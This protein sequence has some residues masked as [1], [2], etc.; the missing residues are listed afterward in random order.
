MGIKSFLFGVETTQAATSLY[1]RNMFQWTNNG[2]PVYFADDRTTYIQEGYENVGAVYEC[3]DLILKKVVACPV[4]VY[5]IK[6]EQKYQKY[7]NLLE[8]GTVE[9]KAL[10]LSMKASVLSEVTVTDI[11]KILDKPNP[12]QS[13]REFI[14]EA[15]GYFLLTGNTFLYANG[16]DVKN[17]KWS[18]LFSL[19]AAQIKIVSGGMFKPVDSYMLDYNQDKSLL[20]PAEQV[21][22]IKTFNPVY[23]N[24]G[25]QLYGLSPLRAYLKKLARAK[26]GD[27]EIN[28]QL[29]NGG[30][31]GLLSP[32]NAQDVLTVDQKNALKERLVE[33][34]DAGDLLA[35]IFPASIAMDWTQIGLPF[36]DMQLL[37]VLDATDKDIYKAYHVPLMYQ[38]N[39]AST[40]NN[41]ATAGKQLI[42]NAVG[43]VCDEI[44]EGL[45][46]A[47]C[48]PVNKRTGKK[49]VIKLDTTSLPEMAA[50]MKEIS[51]WLSKSPELTLNEKRE[52][53]GWGRLEGV[54]NMDIPLVAKTLTRIDQLHLTE[55]GFTSA[56]DKENN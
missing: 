48:E 13:T 17:R 52:V 8:S 43:P 10:A 35:R 41:M 11:Q 6:D 29:N 33:A 3:V 30:A 38:S 19:P 22:H 28:K 44:S 45:T 1:D 25:S 4:I 54:E 50:D 40:Y 49:Y 46:R 16:P 12:Y 21:T 55:E 32:K 56:L 39:D 20:F 14:R 24:T 2:Q 27:K 26:A 9:N 23:S 47:L 18:E 34:K 51:D 7:R 53:K 31:F 5:E 42:Y 15:A 36:P 37:D